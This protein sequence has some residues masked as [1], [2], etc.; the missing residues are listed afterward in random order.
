[1]NETD[2]GIWK[3]LSAWLWTLLAIPLRVIWNKADNAASKD[4]LAAALDRMDK[5]NAEWR[6]V[7]KI[8]FAN[9]ESDRRQFRD[10]IL[11][12]TEKIHMAKNDVL[13]EIAR[14]K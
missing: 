13:L 10:S 9:A 1:M 7:T 8:L 4:E 11:I 5:S 6:E 14:H 12:V 2:P 3:T